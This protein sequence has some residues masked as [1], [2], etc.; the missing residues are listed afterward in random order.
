MTLRPSQNNALYNEQDIKFSIELLVLNIKSLIDQF[1]MMNS[2]TSWP[3]PR[4]Y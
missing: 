3:I 2:N 4:C 1:Y